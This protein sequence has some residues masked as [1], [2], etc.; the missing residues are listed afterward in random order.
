MREHE[1]VRRWITTKADGD[2][3]E[4]TK[5]NNLRKTIF[6]ILF[7]YLSFFFNAGIE[8]LENL[9]IQHRLEIGEN[10]GRYLKKKISVASDFSFLCL[11]AA[12]SCWMKITLPEEECNA[13]ESKRHALLG[14]QSSQTKEIFCH[15]FFFLWQ[16]RLFLTHKNRYRYR[17][18]KYFFFVFVL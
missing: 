18:Q 16:I 5:R 13:I 17:N 1:N 9:S 10:G 14:K 7:I 11:P 15:F 12:T 6:R 2:M 3:I 4:R 8:S